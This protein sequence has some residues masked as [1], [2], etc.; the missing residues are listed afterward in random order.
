MR[1]PACDS[2]FK[3]TRHRRASLKKVPEGQRQSWLCARSPDFDEKGFQTC[4][5]LRR[6]GGCP[7]D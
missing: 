1:K 5:G 2:A 6:A 3:A 4:L 7:R